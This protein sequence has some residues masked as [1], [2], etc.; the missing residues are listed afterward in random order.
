MPVVTDHTALLSGSYWGGIEVTGQPIFVTYSFLGASP[1]S[2][3]HPDAMG[4]A[5]STFQAFDGADRVRARAALQQWAEACG[6]TLLEVA[7]AQGSINF[8]WYDFTGTIHD[9]ADGFAF[10]PFGS[11]NSLTYP[12]FADQMAPGTAAGDIFLDINGAVGG[13]PDTHLLLHEIGHALGF[14][15]PFEVFGSHA[16]TLD[17]ALDTIANTVMSYTG[18]ATGVLGPLDIAA[19]VHVYGAASADGTQVASWS[20]NAALFRLT[21]DGGNGG[22]VIQGVTVADVINGRGGADT[23]TA[24]EGADT[25]NGGAGDDLIIAGSG[26]DQING[27]AG[28]DTMMGGP[29]NDRFTVDDGA[30]LVFEFDEP[31]NDLVVSSASFALWSGIERL[32]LTGTADING[33]GNGAANRIAGNAGANRLDGFGGN[34]NLIGG[35]G[36]DTLVGGAGR[37]ALTGGAGA[38][39]FVFFAADEG[40]DRVTDFTPGLDVII[41]S[42]AGFGGGLAPGAL[43][44]GQFVAHGSTLAT[45]PA[46]TAQFIYHT[47]TGI[48]LFDADGLGGAAAA[49]IAVLSAQPALGAGDI[50]LV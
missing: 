19:A 45:A 15:H 22:D 40:P 5:A 36:N 14:K 25:L 24:F 39:W 27:G 43:G 7:P 32:T 8:A 4:T 29:G 28:A 31:G 20:W 50:L 11:W 38:D 46:G 48:L 17:P 33:A 26:A 13:L 37:D 42:A 9:A 18:T 35:E 34:D 44:A 16:E 2:H 41:A 10:F 23:I 49:R 47:G 1:A 6:L 30:D 3:A 12:Y 21:Q